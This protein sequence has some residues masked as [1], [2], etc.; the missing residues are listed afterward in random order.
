MKAEPLKGKTHGVKGHEYHADKDIY[1]ALLNYIQ[2][3][4]D[5]NVHLDVVIYLLNKNFPDLIKENEE[6]Q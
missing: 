2:D 3:L 5:Y 6:I 4:K 1:S